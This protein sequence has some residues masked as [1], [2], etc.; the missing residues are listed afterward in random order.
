M[1]RT[2][3]IQW[4]N[5]IV[6]G[7]LL[8]FITLALFQ[9]QEVKAATG[10]IIAG[11]QDTVAIFDSK[12]SSLKNLSI[13]SSD[14][15][16]K[17][18]QKTYTDNGVKHT[19]VLAWAPYSMGEDETAT[20]TVKYYD[21]K[22]KRTQSI[23]RQVSFLADYNGGYKA[24]H[25]I[26]SN[27]SKKF[28]IKGKGKLKAIYSSMDRYDSAMFAPFSGGG[29]GE[30]SC[31]LTSDKKNK[32]FTIHAKGY[33]MMGCYVAASFINGEN[34]VYRFNFT[35]PSK[36]G[37]VFTRD[38]KLIKDKS[39]VLYFTPPE[40][41][42]LSVRMEEKGIVSAEIMENQDTKEAALILKG[43]KEGKTEVSLI[44]DAEGKSLVNKYRINV[45]MQAP[46]E[47]AISLIPSE[48]D[49]SYTCI[50]QLTDSSGNLLKSTVGVQYME[51]VPD[52]KEVIVE[53]YDW[54]DFDLRFSSPGT[55]HIAVKLKD[56][57]SK[58]VE[59]YVLTITAG[60]LQYSDYEKISLSSEEEAIAYF[61]EKDYQQW[62]S[63]EYSITFFKNNKITAIQDSNP[64]LFK[65][66][67]YAPGD[68]TYSFD[69]KQQKII[70][71]DYDRTIE[72]AYEII[73]KE[74]VRF[75]ID[76]RMLDFVQY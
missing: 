59:E 68:A 62:R 72:I 45:I 14:K 55:Y 17:V 47:E 67:D 52:S 57:D 56:L 75:S 42:K 31:V 27:G 44:Y 51:I 10:G 53:G 49:R 3:R 66:G 35:M 30:E 5:K 34:T 22:K 70:V 41:G 39:T 64:W 29:D 74:H 50:Y 15:N 37:S 63:G 20:V 7:F 48:E 19:V 12:A 25:T 32:T 61:C 38:M 43:I 13:A 28:T 65:S 58:S 9:K 23:K 16:V 21:T 71:K 2:V 11:D 46:V 26:A 60:E 76:G 33:G 40:S 36:D 18:K 69:L 4:I 73:S 1:K 24:D 54:D 6:Y 8:I